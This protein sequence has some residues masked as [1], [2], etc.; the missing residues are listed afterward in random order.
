MSKGVKTIIGKPTET[1]DLSQWV[2]IDSGLT[3]GEPA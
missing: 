1:V 3:L 2:L